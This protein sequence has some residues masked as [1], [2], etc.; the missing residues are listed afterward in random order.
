MHFRRRILQ[1][2]V[3]QHANATLCVPQVR[4]K[5]ANMQQKKTKTLHCCGECA[6]K[7]TGNHFKTE[8]NPEVLPVRNVL[9][10]DQETN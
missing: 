8:L 1:P 9:T 5:E 3:T 10:K 4:A 2:F 7:G 6:G